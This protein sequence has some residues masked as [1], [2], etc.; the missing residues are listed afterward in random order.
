MTTSAITVSFA[1]AITL[2]IRSEHTAST[3]HHQRSSSRARCSGKLRPSASIRAAARRAR[4]SAQP[5]PTGWAVA[6]TQ[7][8]SFVVAHGGPRH[9]P[10]GLRQRYRT[11]R[12]RTRTPRCYR[13]MRRTIPPAFI[14]PSRSPSPT[15]NHDTHT[16]IVLQYV[17]SRFVRYLGMRC[18]PDRRTAARS[19]PHPDLNTLPMYCDILFQITVNSATV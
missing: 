4:C 15:Y 10:P 14:S 2:C 1:T 16:A 5:T 9:G 17:P 12:Q 6:N 19:H 7:R 8:I 11:A 3:E 13:R 18:G